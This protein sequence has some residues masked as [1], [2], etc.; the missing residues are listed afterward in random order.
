MTDRK[1]NQSKEATMNARNWPEDYRRFFS[2]DSD[3]TLWYRGFNAR[4][5]RGNGWDLERDGE[6]VTRKPN[7]EKA[8]KFINR[9]VYN[10]QK[11]SA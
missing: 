7:L 4:K 9:R 3:G 10:E 8:Y 1:N 11:A 5:V 2:K 6:V